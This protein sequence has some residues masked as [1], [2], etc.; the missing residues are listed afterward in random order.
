M[1]ETAAAFAPVIRGEASPVLTTALLMGLRARGESGA[2]IAGAAQA[3]REAMIV[4]ESSRR[5]ALVDTCGTGGGAVRTLNVSTAAAFVAAGAGV[6]VAKHGN[7]SYSSRSGSADVLEAMGIDIGLTPE[8]AAQVLEATGLVF[9]FAPTYHPAMRHVAPM[10]RE[11]GVATIMNLLGPMLNPAGARRQVVGVSD[12]P[13]APLVADALARLGTRHAVVVHGEIGM[14]EISPAGPTQ[15]WEVRD[16]VVEP[17]TL[18]PG[19][20]DLAADDLAPLDGGAPADNA[21]RIEALFD[22]EGAPAVRAAVL[23]NAGA[24]LYVAGHG[25]SLE[26]SMIRADDALRSGKAAAA[27]AR[28]RQAAPKAREA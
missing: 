18:E 11:L 2:E 21:R 10:R 17:W 14:D 27:L 5:D 3:L 22:G 19:A 15:V 16:G 24:A 8:R 6:P 12:R 26:E 1:Q 9:L 7:R 23:L 13:R 25:W 4:L 28:L 20:F